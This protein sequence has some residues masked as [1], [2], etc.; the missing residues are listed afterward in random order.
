M[1][2]AK[3]SYTQ[4]TLRPRNVSR[5]MKTT[6]PRYYSSDSFVSKGYGYILWT[7][8]N[9]VQTSRLK[10]YLKVSIKGVISPPPTPMLILLFV[11]HVAS[12]YGGGRIYVI[13]LTRVAFQI[14]ET[15]SLS[16]TTVAG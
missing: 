11:T 3:L 1:Y 12:E 8:N 2:Y 14:K 9:Q 5:E 15:S 4:A 6:N 16:S 10:M 7:I 13:K